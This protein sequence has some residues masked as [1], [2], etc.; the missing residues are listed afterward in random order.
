MTF[1][2]YAL[3]AIVA[4][5]A[6]VG[7][8]FYARYSNVHNVQTRLFLLFL[9]SLSIQNVAEIRFFITNAGTL[10]PP[11]I[12]IGKLYFS[13][14]ALALAFLVH[15]ALVVS[16]NWRS[17]HG[18]ISIGGAILVYAPH[19]FLQALLWSTP[20]VISGFEPMGYTYTKIPGP[21]YFTFEAYAVAYLGATAGLLLYGAYT[22][23][24]AFRRLQNKLLLFGFIPFIALG[25][26]IIA[27][28]R[29]G[30]RGFNTTATLPIATVFL[31]AVAAYATHQ[32]R[33]FDI[34]FFIPWSTVRKRKTAFYARIQA[35]IAE[36]AQLP[37][38]NKIVQ[39]LSEA[40]H[41][42]VV[43]I[44]GP[45]PAIAMAG[46][47]FSVARFPHEEL[48]KIDHIVV[49][50]EIAEANP[51]MFALM[52]RHKVAAVVPFHPHSQAAAS[53]MLLGEAF[54]EH[55]YTPLDFKV[56]ESLFD[57][58]ADHFL[59]KQLLL[60]SQLTEAQR[61]MH[62]LQERLA[63]AWEQLETAR[64]KQRALEK[65]N[66]RLQRKGA[67]VLRHELTEVELELMDEAIAGKKTLD[68]YGAEFEARLIER[69]LEHCDG[70]R[71]RA[72]QILG[73]TPYT[74]HHKCLRFGLDTK[75]K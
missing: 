54:S 52:K 65:E 40:L 9:F 62:L 31:V 39:S 55:V 70:D 8:F 16:R 18:N 23:T 24:T 33:L 71:N 69:V 15:L 20:L 75:I 30:F 37:T 11:P 57:R 21:L 53:W 43:L 73:L 14:T 67:Q 6:K 28:Q 4:L 12:Q 68:E 44:G 51:D 22:Q 42:P 49:A 36:I 63:S 45:K 41:C 2:P 17:P 32:Y 3:P 34:G 46:D 35:I 58:L 47:A 1:A 72:A 50:N 60:R 25:L 27:L 38:V 56:V 48:R 59:D 29:F 13:M 66:Y 19:V 64:K 10:A 5:L 7:M 26:T 61:E 74:L